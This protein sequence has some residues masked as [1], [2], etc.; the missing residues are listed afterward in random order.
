MK[1]I[2]TFGL[3]AVSALAGVLESRQM[4][5]MSMASKATSKYFPLPP[6]PEA[7]EGVKRMRGMY[8]PFTIPGYKT[9]TAMSQ[10]MHEGGMAMPSMNV[11]P[12]VD[13]ATFTYLKADMVFKDGT[14]AN[15]NS[16]VYLQ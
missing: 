4:P 5:G 6:R 12:P 14:Q 2:I 11:K 9:S 3:F 15:Y 7:P 13:D 1:A 16:G 8:G 10:R